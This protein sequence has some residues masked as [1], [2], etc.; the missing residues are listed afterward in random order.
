[1]NQGAIFNLFCYSPLIIHPYILI[2]LFSFSLLT[3]TTSST[4]D[5]KFQACEPKTCG[6]GQ[7]ISYPFYIKGKHEPFCGYPGFELT[8]DHNNGFPIITTTSSSQQYIVDEIFYDNQSVRVS[9][10]SFSKPKSNQC[11]PRR[12][13]NFSQYSRRFI[14]AP[15]QKHVLLFY[16]CNST[17]LP[18]KLKENIVGC[19]DGNKTSSVVALY[20]EDRNLS[21]MPKYCKG[22]VVNI[23]V[24]N[25]KGGI[26]ELLKRGYVLNW[27]ATNCGGCMNSGGRCGFDLER[28]VYSFRCYCRDGVHDQTCEG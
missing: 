7:N 3:T 1:M 19:D 25:E 4:I 13:M 14:V 22:D 23:S 27:V 8:C 12:I 18:E 11:I 15:N 10:P 21:L 20:R 16:G 6:N 2:I 26:K 5:P 9:I 17:T 24:V 28:D